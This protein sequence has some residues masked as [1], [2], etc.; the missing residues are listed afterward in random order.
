MSSAQFAAGHS[1][2]NRRHRKERRATG[3]G[4]LKTNNELLRRGCAH[5]RALAKIVKGTPRFGSRY[6]T[7]RW[8]RPG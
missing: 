7:S 1:K 3:E 5:C 2:S 6:A 8:R 4:S